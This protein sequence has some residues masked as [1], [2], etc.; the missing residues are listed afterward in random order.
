MVVDRLP[1]LGGGAG[2][3]AVVCLW[4]CGF[5]LGGPLLWMLGMGYVILLWASLSLSYNYFFK[6][7][8]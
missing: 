3:S 6:A 5:C 2:L 8:M 1:R 4:L 7:M